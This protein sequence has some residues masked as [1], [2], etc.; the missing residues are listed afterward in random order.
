MIKYP[1]RI[2]ICLTLLLTSLQETKASDTQPFLTNLDSNQNQTEIS[3]PDSLSKRYLY[4]A[5]KVSCLI[6]QTRL[7]EVSVGHFNFSVSVYNDER[8]KNI[9][10][11]GKNYGI[12]IFLI[13]SSMDLTFRIR[14]NALNGEFPIEIITFRYNYRDEQGYISSLKIDFDKINDACNSKLYHDSSSLFELMSKLLSLKI[15]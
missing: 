10:F 14:S 12:L 2:V 6:G 8:K 7:G 15:N 13:E 1:N 11:Q 5:M 4:L 9:I 3:L